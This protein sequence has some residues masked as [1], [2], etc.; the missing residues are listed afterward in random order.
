VRGW[1]VLI[2]AS[3]QKASANKNEVC[4]SASVSFGDVLKQEELPR[5]F[6]RPECGRRGEGGVVR[7]IWDGLLGRTK[8]AS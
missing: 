5:R 4:I 7:A 8:A 2:R 1:G 3:A 6:C